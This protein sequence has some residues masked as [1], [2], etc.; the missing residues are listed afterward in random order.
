MRFWLV[1]LGGSGLVLGAVAHLYVRLRMKPPEDLDDY[2][3]EFEEQHPAY[4]R[5]LQWRQWTM[6]VASLGTML[7]FLALVL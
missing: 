1:I 5:Y 6:G 2:Y 7:L 3:H 4:R